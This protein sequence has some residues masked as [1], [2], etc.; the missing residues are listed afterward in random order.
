MAKD[1]YATLGVSRSASEKEIRTAY[2]R[3]ARKLHPD[4]NPGDK[5]SE[6]RFKEVNAAY[7]VLSDADKR[8]KYDLYGENWEHADE[9]ERARQA[10]GAGRRF[11]R[12]AGGPGV[13]YQEFSFGE[14]GDLGDLFG[15][16]FGGGRRGHAR[17]RSLDV[18]QPVDV[19]LEEAYEGTARM[20]LLNAVDGQQPR[21]LEVRIPPGVATGSR[22]RMAG[23]GLSADGQKGD[24]Y[25]VV[26]V[27][28]HERFERKGDDLNTEIDVP[29]TLAV[30]GGEVAVPV[31]GKKVALKIPPLTQ[32]GRVFRLAGL[33]MPHLNTADRKGDVYVKVRLKL[34]EQLTDEERKLFEELKALGV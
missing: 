13:D 7:E 22:I 23:E 30:L 24:L 25:L 8:R 34:P 1:Y 4:V 27:R 2:R 21:R 12:S 5:A 6:S 14:V 26:T 28:P 31:I 17:P 18:E 3:L 19:S 33:G 9:I 32:N 15:G 11:Y 16:I 20:L 29:V 10:Q